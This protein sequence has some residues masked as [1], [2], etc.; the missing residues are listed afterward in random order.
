M[1]RGVPNEMMPGIWS[2]LS[3]YGSTEHGGKN[4]RNCKAYNPSVWRMPQLFCHG[5]PGSS[6]KQVAP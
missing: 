3:L 5:Q 6:L 4:D 2:G 1:I